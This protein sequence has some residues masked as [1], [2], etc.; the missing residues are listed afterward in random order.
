[1][2]LIKCSECSK[3]I[4]DKAMACPGCGAP[5]IAAAIRATSSAPKT[6][7]KNIGCGTVLVAFPILGV[8]FFAILMAMN[9]EDSAV[10]K[11]RQNAQ[12]SIDLCWKDYER[13]SFDPSTKRFIASACEKMESDY[14]QKYGRAP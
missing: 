1:M 12:S 8:L 13:K 6:T 5:I 4:S 10:K 3:E 14:E 11:E 9:P 2:A 7:N